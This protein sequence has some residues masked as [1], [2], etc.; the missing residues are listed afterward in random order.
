MCSHYRYQPVQCGLVLAETLMFFVGGKKVLNPVLT[1]FYIISELYGVITF[2][3]LSLIFFFSFPV[4]IKS[5]EQC[6]RHVV[7]SDLETEWRLKLT[8]RRVMA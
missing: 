6:L 1:L 3:F 7:P 8:Y 2:F 4:I 5:P